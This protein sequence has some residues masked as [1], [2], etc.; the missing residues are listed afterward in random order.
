MYECPYHTCHKPAILVILI[1][2][3]NVGMIAD[4]LKRR[5]IH[6]KANRPFLCF[7]VMQIVDARYNKSGDTHNK[8]ITFCGGNMVHYGGDGI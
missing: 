3:A 5:L 2:I 1:T 6:F 4:N 7:S 8:D